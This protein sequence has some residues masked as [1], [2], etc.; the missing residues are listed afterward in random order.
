MV[1]YVCIRLDQDWIHSNKPIKM[2][3][4]KFAVVATRSTDKPGSHRVM[5]CKVHT[6]AK[7]KCCYKQAIKWACVSNGNASSENNSSTWSG[8]D[9]E[10]GMLSWAERELSGSGLHHRHQ[11]WATWMLT[12]HISVVQSIDK[13]IVLP[14][15]VCRSE[16]GR[17]ALLLVNWFCRLSGF[18]SAHRQVLTLALILLMQA[19]LTDEAG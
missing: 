3:A 5:L 10:I 15:L 13:S 18:Q 8:T 2:V 14:Q 4:V 6:A 7:L 12:H 17:A 9:S 1:W 16:S 11:C 19:A